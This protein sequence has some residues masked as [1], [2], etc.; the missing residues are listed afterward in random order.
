[1]FSFDRNNYS[2]SEEYLRYQ[3][4]ILERE[5]EL[6]SDYNILE[7]LLDQ[8]NDSILNSKVENYQ[9]NTVI[10]VG[11]FSLKVK[12]RSDMTRPVDRGHDGYEAKT[13][14]ITRLTK[15]N[16]IIGSFNIID[17]PIKKAIEIKLIQRNEIISMIKNPINYVQFKDV[18]LECTT[19]FLLSNIKPISSTAQLFQIIQVFILFVTATIIGNSLGSSKHFSITKKNT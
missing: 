2:Y 19:G 11:V 13:I 14:N 3:N 5:I 6:Y 7:K 12:K 1:L 8:K 9:V 4:T 17:E 18:W 16:E 10:N 15:P